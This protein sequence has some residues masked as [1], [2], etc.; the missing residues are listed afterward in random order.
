MEVWKV[1]NNK[2]ISDAIRIR[3]EQ[4]TSISHKIC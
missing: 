2:N 4:S 1:E 3:K